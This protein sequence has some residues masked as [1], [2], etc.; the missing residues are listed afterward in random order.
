MVDRVKILNFLY[1]N[2]MPQ[3][4]LAQRLGITE[5]HLSKVL[6]GRIKPSRGLEGDLYKMIKGGKR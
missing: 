3:Y 2:D 5:T 6:R 1:E 4:R